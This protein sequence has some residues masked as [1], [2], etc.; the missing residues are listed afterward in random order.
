[1]DPVSR[2]LDSENRDSRPRKDSTADL[3]THMGDMQITR[4]GDMLMDDYDVGDEKSDVAEITPDSS[5]DEP[6]DPLA[7]DCAPIPSSYA[8]FIPRANQGAVEGMKA[9]MLPLIPDL[10]PESESIYTWDIENYRS[11][12]RKERSP[13]FDCGGHPW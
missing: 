12:T 6:Q 13:K 3:Q 9:R 8:P 10:E 7:H 1:M 11:L 2:D 5:T 4:G